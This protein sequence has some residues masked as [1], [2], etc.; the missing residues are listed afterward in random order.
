MTLILEDNEILTVDGM[1]C[2]GCESRI[3]NTLN[4]LEGVWAKANASTKEVTVLMKNKID[5]KTLKKT[6]NT[7]GDYT[8]MKYKEV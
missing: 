4:N 7:I 8:V 2:Q 1:A 5:E 3:E 6:V